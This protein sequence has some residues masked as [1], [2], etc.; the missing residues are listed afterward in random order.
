M[1]IRIRTSGGITIALCAAETDAEAGDLYL[2]D[3]QHQALAAKFADDWQGQTVTWRYDTEWNEMKKHKLRD[4]EEELNR[5]LR[6]QL[7]D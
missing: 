3:N 5:W 4:A 2:D 7:N 1:S 6:D